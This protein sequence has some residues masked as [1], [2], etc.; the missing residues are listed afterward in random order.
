MMKLRYIPPN[1]NGWG[2]E[3]LDKF[4]T[5]IAKAVVRQVSE[6]E[7]VKRLQEEQRQLKAGVAPSS[8]CG[9]A[10]PALIAPPGR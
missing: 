7:T 8:G 9:A 5:A 6:S 3:A 2:E 10:P 1:L 4:H